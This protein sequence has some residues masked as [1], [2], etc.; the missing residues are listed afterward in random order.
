MPNLFKA[1]VASAF[2]ELLMA[3]LRTIRCRGAP[4]R[5]ASENDYM[6]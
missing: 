2:A 5:A 6:S 3:M 1:S 4:P